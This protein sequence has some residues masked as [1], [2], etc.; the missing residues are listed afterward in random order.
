MTLSAGGK[1]KYGHLYEFV[2]IYS[3]L[4]ILYPS[5]YN[6]QKERPMARSTLQ[7][8]RKSDRTEPT[9]KPAKKTAAK[10]VRKSVGNSQQVNGEDRESMIAE[11]AY[12]RA[13]RRGFAGGDPVV[14]W[15][16]AEAEVDARLN[17][18]LH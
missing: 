5:M 12:F 15:L 1:D 17:G 11:A 6:L 18:Q 7:T 14:D 2:R 16:E 4:L 9:A 13:E 10:P 3:D 8:P